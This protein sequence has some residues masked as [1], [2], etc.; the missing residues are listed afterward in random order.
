[1]KG[2][3]LDFSFVVGGGCGRGDWSWWLIEPRAWGE[4]EAVEAAGPGFE[5]VF[6]W[7]AVGIELGEDKF[8]ISLLFDVGRDAGDTGQGVELA[9]VVHWVASVLVVFERLEYFEDG[10]LEDG[11]MESE[12]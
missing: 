5:F 3:I 6:G 10:D 1:M 9:D 4:E 12:I 2:D 8:L 11:L 7:V